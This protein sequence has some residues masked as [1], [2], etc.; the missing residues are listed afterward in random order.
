MKRLDLINQIIARKEQL[1]ITIENLA[2]LS[3]VSI[4]TI[5]RAVNM[6]IILFIL[7]IEVTCFLLSILV[8]CLC[9]RSNLP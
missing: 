7:I 2:K 1:N 6:C 3:C 8:V 4:R 9:W 5:N